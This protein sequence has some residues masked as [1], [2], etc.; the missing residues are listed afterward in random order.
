MDLFLRF[1]AIVFI[2]AGLPFFLALGTAL[3]SLWTIGGP[4]KGNEEKFLLLYI[5][6][7]TSGLLSAS[8]LTLWVVAKLA[9]PLK[10][11]K[12]TQDLSLSQP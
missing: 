4:P 6:F 5:A 7:A 9:Y 8:G 10:R 3:G 12:P 2:L 1:F 11:K